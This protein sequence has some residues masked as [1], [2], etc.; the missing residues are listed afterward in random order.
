MFYL[1]VNV[2]RVRGLLGRGQLALPWTEFAVSAI[3][4]KASEWKNVKSETGQSEH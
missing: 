2:L 4:T 3:T 1:I